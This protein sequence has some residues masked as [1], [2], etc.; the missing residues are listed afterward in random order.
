MT[1]PNDTPSS[2]FCRTRPEPPIPEFLTETALADRLALS[3]RTLQ[4]WRHKGGGPR[5]VKMGGA[6]RYRWRDVEAWLAE[7]SREHT[8]DPGPQA[9]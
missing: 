3:R 5:F 9:A 7:Q 6:V 1:T 4:M 2:T 8:S